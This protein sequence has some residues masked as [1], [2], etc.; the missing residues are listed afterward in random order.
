[1]NLRAART[2]PLIIAALAVTLVPVAVARAAP[3]DDKRAEAQK[4]QAQIDANGDRI[5]ALGERYDGAKLR[6]DD[7][8]R[9][10]AD[11]RV[12][13]DRAQQQWQAIRSRLA[14][15]AAEI[16]VSA[17]TQNPLQDFDVANVQE[18]MARSRYSAAMSSRDDDLLT[19]VGN[20][21]DQLASQRKNLDAARSQAKA[22]V[23]RIASTRAQVEAANARQHQLL[24]QVRGQLATLI[25][26]E[27]QRREAQARAQAA[28]YAAAASRPRPATRN[29]PDVG[30]STALPNVPTSGGVSQEIAYARAQLGKPYVFNTAGPN[31][32]D[33]SGL[34]MMAWAQAGVSMPHYSG[35]QF[36]M[37]PHVPLD[38]LQPGD[39][40][41]KGPGGA[42]H[43]ALYVG[44]GMQIAATHTG[45]YVLLQPVQ[46]G[47]LSGAVRP[48]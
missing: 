28:R 4:L 38:Q 23:D 11:A 41:F 36:S 40:V 47:S 6:L 26:Q 39:L 46:Y 2:A 16:Y 1:M 5:A 48:G 18:M 33:C 30:P 15:R 10:I 34:T 8:N 19:K 42:D 9:A 21:R 32:F 3:I 22:D 37:F 7:A 17:G 12:R 35:S 24:G 31:T 43:V 20:A 44:G 14:A 29:S 27:Q 13:Y 25:A 45:S